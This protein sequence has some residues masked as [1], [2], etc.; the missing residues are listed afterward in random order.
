MAMAVC[1]KIDEADQ[2]RFGWLNSL[3]ARNGV[4]LG[5]DVRQMVRGD[6]VHE[7][8]HDF[9]IAHTAMKPA[10]EE[11]ELYGDGDDGG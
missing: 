10:Q 4:Q 8:A 3:L 9:V 6:V 2:G 1:V 5:I 7:N 11:D